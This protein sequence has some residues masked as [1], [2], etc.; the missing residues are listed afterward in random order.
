MTIIDRNF[1]WHVR[2]KLFIYRQVC[3]LTKI[4]K[5]QKWGE[6]IQKWISRSLLHS[7]MLTRVQ[8][9]DCKTKICSGVYLNTLISVCV[10]NL[11]ETKKTCHF[12]VLN[13]FHD[14]IRSFWACFVLFLSQNLWQNQLLY[15]ICFLLF[16]K[17]DRKNSSSL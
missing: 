9:E 5:A 12:F 3:W 7:F 6:K 15:D 8:I 13:K 4:E 2:R 1:E 10:C 11:S 16:R 14:K 17:G